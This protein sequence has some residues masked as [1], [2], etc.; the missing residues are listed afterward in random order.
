MITSSKKGF[1]LLETI[2]YVTLATVVLY[3]AAQLYMVIIVTQEKNHAMADVTLA[4]ENALVHITQTIR[5][6]RNVTTPNA[7]FASD[8]MSLEMR[9]GAPYPT[10]EFS[11]VDGVIMMQDGSQPPVAITPSNI[12]VSNLQFSNMSTV[13]PYSVQVSFT[14]TSNSSDRA[15]LTYSDTFYATATTR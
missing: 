6:S 8:E 13:Q 12:V 15:D 5:D 14:A 2:L 3:A 4:S 11:L 7:G 1:T 9:D 10:E